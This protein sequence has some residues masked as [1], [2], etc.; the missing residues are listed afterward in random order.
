MEERGRNSDRSKT[1]GPRPASTGPSSE[2]S[3]AEVSLA[4]VQKDSEEDA[5]EA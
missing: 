2:S 1:R 3:G 4:A 5:G